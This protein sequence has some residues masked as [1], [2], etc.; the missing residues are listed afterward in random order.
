[1]AARWGV[2]AA[3]ERTGD[4]AI[5]STDEDASASRAS[6]V[7]LGYLQDPFA[8]LFVRRVQRRPPLINVGT[9]LRT[10]ALDTLVARFLDTVVGAGLRA[11]I[12]S[13][14]AGTDTRF[15]RL[16]TADAAAQALALAR[17]VEIDFAETTARKARTIMSQASL[18]QCLTGDVGIGALDDTPSSR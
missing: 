7:S 10:W 18:R 3:E 16:A 13:L 4:D 14:G 2:D 1:M 9:F 15:F 12:V 8:S 5:R 17:Y 6:S 11:Q